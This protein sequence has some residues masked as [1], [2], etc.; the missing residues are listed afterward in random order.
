MNAGFIGEQ[1][2]VQ[3]DKAP[4]LSKRPDCPDRFVWRGTT[5]HIVELLREW[6]DYERRGR[7]ADNMQPAHSALAAK[8]GSWGVGR[9]YYRVRVEDGRIFELYYDR[10]PQ[11]ADRRQGAWFLTQLLAEK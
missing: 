3:F 11:D 7:M 10:A 8:R 2:E 1:V 5:Y 6:R 4:L 9:F